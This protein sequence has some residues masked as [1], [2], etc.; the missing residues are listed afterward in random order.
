MEVILVLAAVA[1]I[2]IYSFIKSD[3]RKV[4]PASK[5]SRQAPKKR[6]YADQQTFHWSDNGNYGFEVVGESNY[7]DALR[8]LAGDHG[9][10]SAAAEHIATLI[11]EDTNKF[12]NKAVCVQINGLTV[13]Y[14]SRQDARSFR[15]RLGSKGLTGLATTCPA[16]IAGG[17]LKDGQ[18]FNYGVW[19][20][21][22]PFD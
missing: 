19:L 6:S 15:R 1:A 20:D 21:L 5:P 3:K 7:Q 9:D 22:K 14:L 11:P 13:G 2:S 10:R 4:P 12:D 17:G 18:R 8:S 16:V